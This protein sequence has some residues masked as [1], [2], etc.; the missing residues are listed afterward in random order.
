MI[1]ITDVPKSFLLQEDCCKRRLNDEKYCHKL[2]IIALI[3][4][5]IVLYI[6]RIKGPRSIFYIKRINTPKTNWFYILKYLDLL[7]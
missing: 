1:T 3:A 2:G 5:V 6:G 7:C 4:L